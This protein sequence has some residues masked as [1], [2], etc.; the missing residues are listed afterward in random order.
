MKWGNNYASESVRVQGSRSSRGL[1]YE[2]EGPAASI[3]G[4]GSDRKQWE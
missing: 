3:P 4:L 1:G 2:V